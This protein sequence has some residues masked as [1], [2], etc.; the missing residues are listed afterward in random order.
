MINTVLGAILGSVIIPFILWGIKN[1]IRWIRSNK[2]K[3]KVLGTFANNNV[4]STIF[5]RDLVLAPKS[6]VI[7]QDPPFMLSET[8]NI[9]DLWPAVEGKAIALI[10]NLLGEINKTKNI[11]VKPM[12][13]DQGELDTNVMVLGAQAKKSF[14]F[15]SNMDDVGYRMGVDEIYDNQTDEIIV[16]EEGFGYGIIIKARNPHYVKA[17]D[18][19][20]FLIGG[21]GVLGTIA[22]AYYFRNHIND[23]AKK[24]GKSPFSIIVRAPINAGEEAVQRLSSYDKKFG[25]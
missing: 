12:S 22:A 11:I 24:F 14:D 15:Y 19:P 2:Q 13:T 4:N 5:F 10:L 1:L 23:L 6:K 17:P 7:A 9:R 8:P 21:Y 3:L 25:S 20:A 16:R 18:S